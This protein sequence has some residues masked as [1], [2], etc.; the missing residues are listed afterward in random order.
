MKRTRR[1]KLQSRGWQDSLSRWAGQPTL[2]WAFTI[3]S[4]LSSI[5]VA[6]DEA[7]TN[8][9]PQLTP[10]QMF[11]GG[12]T[13]YTNWVEFSTGVYLRSGNNGAFQQRQQSRSGPFGGIEDFHYQAD[14]ATNTVF[15]VDG[16]G[17]FD[18]NYYKLRLD[19]TREKVGYLRFSVSEFRTWSN[20]DGGFDP[21]S[22]LWYPLS[23]DALGLDR[24]EISFEGG[25][26]LEN[27]PAVTFKYRH[28]GREGEKNSTS[29]GIAHPD[30]ESRGLSPSFYDINE[31]NDSFQ[32][33]VTHTIDKTGF[34]VGL[35]FD[36]GKLDD[37]LKITQAPGEP[38]FQ[39]KIT[40]RQGTTY[41]MFNVHAFTETWITNNLMFSSAFSYSDLNT[42]FSGSRI[43]GSD[44]DV[45]YA[46]NAL[47]GFGYF[48][49]NGGSRLHE[50]VG[51]LNLFYKPTPVLDIVPS[52]RVLKEDTDA[53]SSGTETLADQAITD[54]SSVSE[55][56]VLDVR[57]RLDLRYIGITNW[58]F[59]ARGDFTEGDGNLNQAGGLGPVNGIGVPTIERKTDDG[60]FF[61][62]YSAGAR[63]Y[64]LRQVTVDVGGYYKLNSYDYNHT[65]DSTLNNS[66]DR[67][68]AYLVI[69]DFETY[70]G[71]FRLALRPWS[72]V[73]FAT[74]YEFQLSN[75]HTQPDPI[76]GLG[77]VESARMVSHIIAEDISWSP[78]SR[79]YLQA[80]VNYVLSDTKTPA[81]DITQ[82]ILRSQNNYWVVNFSSNFVLNNKTD[83]KLNYFYY[84][85]DNYADNSTVAVIYGAASEEH[86]VTATLTH[87][88]SS[89][90]RWTLRYGFF[91]SRDQ[92]SGGNQNYDAHLLFSSIQYRF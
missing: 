24:S 8:A 6:A 74:R 91:A 12:E 58:V 90:L 19:L 27:K 31:H 2:R 79:L 15:S 78:W 68:P 49:L 48:G 10:E 75:I 14:V 39:R 72:D 80:G 47:N 55:R 32:L 89:N 11:E 23:G 20:G 83:L 65:L 30:G 67:Y 62:K 50:Y 37:A 3:V 28:T 13:I 86:G 81:S 43:Y 69:Q 42:D 84:Q 29:W 17:I 76:S 5:S 18:N 52:I 41:D 61:Q 87:R 66:F 34:G 60:R 22:N 35:R 9:P 45:S 63:W 64:P 51:D 25:L 77:E 7:S 40:D 92:L 73:T 21:S 53:N 44:F 88:I 56:R 59:Y 85:A 16:R 46:P 57:E 4:S 38:E 82:A 71:N 26:T 33:D 70:D 1:H 36:T 54:F